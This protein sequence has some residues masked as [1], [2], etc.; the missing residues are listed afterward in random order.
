MFQF[1]KEQILNKRAEVRTDLVNILARDIDNELSSWLQ[2]EREGMVT[3]EVTVK[4]PPALEG[5]PE[6][7]REALETAGFSCKDEGGILTIW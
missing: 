6:E 2:K 7:I 3:N 5:L 1:T 4:I